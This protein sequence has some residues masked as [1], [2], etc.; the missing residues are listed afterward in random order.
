M[1]YQGGRY[2]TPGADDDSL[3]WL[4]STG[5]Q[6]PITG[7]PGP[8]YDYGPE[9]E[10]PEYAD[11]GYN[12]PM[13]QHPG[14]GQFQRGYHAQPRPAREP[15]ALPP[16][17]SWVPPRRPQGPPPPRTRPGGRWTGG[18]RFGGGP[19]GPSSSR[20]GARRLFAICVAALIVI[21][22]VLFAANGVKGLEWGLGK[23]GIHMIHPHSP[24]KTVTTNTIIGNA[25]VTSVRGVDQPAL[26]EADFNFD[27]T[28][29]VDKSALLF[30]CWYSQ[31]YHA[32]A[33]ASA[34][35]NLNPGKAWWA[36]PGNYTMSRTGKQVSVTLSLPQPTLPD[37]HQ[38]AID[39]TTSGP[40]GKP[41]HSFTYP[42]LGCGALINPHFS[43]DEMGKDMQEIAYA[44]ATGH[45]I[46]L[47]GITMQPGAPSAATI[48]S[49]VLAAAE[50]EAVTMYTNDFI[51]P[52]L[53]RLGYHL[54]QPVTIKW[55]PQSPN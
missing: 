47:D 27:Y 37:V 44:L 17:P 34:Y 39:N 49:K 20:G 12:Q 24:L 25:I 43:N 18:R 41:D 2:N 35:V 50:A 23:L 54:R 5:P 9:Y 22:V 13:G 45:A 21:P 31:T 46:T 36:K 6:G 1:A 55:V 16:G 14:A 32:Q 52:T 30:K 33:H 19:N 4:N 15:L 51:G 38:V 29:K 7:Q 28:H 42:G 40:I 26:G 48:R 11:P 8:D 10:D 53:T 3:P